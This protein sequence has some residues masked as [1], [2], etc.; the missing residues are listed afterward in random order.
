[1]SRTRTK[2]IQILAK[3]LRKNQTDTEKIMWHLLKQ[4]FPQVHFRRQYQI[5]NYIV[6]FVSL[7]HKLV[8][9]CDAVDIQ[10]KKIMKEILF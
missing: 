6:D 7:K 2:K 10:K 4:N 9:E 5:K 3:A 8:I 1:M